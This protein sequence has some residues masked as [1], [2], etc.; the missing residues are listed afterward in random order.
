MRQFSSIES[1]NAS[2]EPDVDE[3]FQK[4]KLY[5]GE[6]GVAELAAFKRKV[7]N[8]ALPR[9]V[10]KES[11]KLKKVIKRVAWANEVGRALTV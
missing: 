1:C 10:R 3:R 8:F 5:L 11:K 2:L 9:A 7:V 6:E 4:L